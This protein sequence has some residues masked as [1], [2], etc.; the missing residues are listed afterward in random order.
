MSW[1]IYIII[2]VAGYFLGNIS[3][4]LFVGRYMA[5]IDIRQHGS[6]NAGM[7]NVLRTM[8]WLP[9]VLTLAGDVLK[10]VIA[11]LFGRWLGGEAGAM[12][13]GLAAIAGHNWPV[14]LGFKG[15]RGIATSLGA[16]I[17]VN[18][19]IAIALVLIQAAVVA[20]TRYMSVASLVSA[21]AYFVLTFIARF[22]A[23]TEIAFALTVTLLAVYSH[24]ENIGRLIKHSENRLDFSKIRLTSTKK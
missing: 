18:P 1:T 4:G 17:V 12:L 24:R 19:Y 22:G 8:G 10:G 5:N 13:G 3:T 14:L 23:F 15:G 9:S 2:A 6:G 16:I 21:A 7:T 11:G 20:L